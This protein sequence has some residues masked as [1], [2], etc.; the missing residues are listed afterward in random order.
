MEPTISKSALMEETRELEIGIREKRKL[1]FYPL[2]IKDFLGM[3]TAIEDIIKFYFNDFLKGVQEAKNDN[4]TETLKNLTADDK[5]QDA[6]DLSLARNIE[7]GKKFLKII[8]DNSVSIFSIATGEDGDKLLGEML[9]RHYKD[10]IQIVFDMNYES[11]TEALGELM[12]I[13]TQAMKAKSKSEL[14]TSSSPA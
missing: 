9:P 2:S 12:G 10:A 5:T 7:I 3:E 6:E 1:V 4:I 13:I 11:A 8:R 14:T